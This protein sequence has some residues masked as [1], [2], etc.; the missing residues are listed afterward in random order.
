MVELIRKIKK[1]RL[2]N[3]IISKIY[4]ASNVI[5]NKS[6]RGNANYIIVSSDIANIINK[7][8]E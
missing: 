8:D 6:I 4:R 1:L 2:H 5:N 7:L 3:R